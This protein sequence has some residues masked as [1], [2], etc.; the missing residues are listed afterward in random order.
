MWLPVDFYHWLSCFD[1]IIIFQKFHVKYFM[2]DF[3]M[4]WW[5]SW[6]GSETLAK[7]FQNLKINVR[8]ALVFF[9][10]I[11]NTW[12][13]KI[14]KLI[15]TIVLLKVL[16]IWSYDFFPSFWQFVDPIPKEL[17]RHGGQEWIK[18]IFDTL[19]WCK[20]YSNEGVLHQPEIMVWA[21]RRVG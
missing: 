17:H 11:I 6:S 18:P 15:C 13:L 10:I 2:A 21:I 8:I 1:S 16:P 9:F 19:F 20:P 14:P 12:T 3:C 7:I 4:P 5:C